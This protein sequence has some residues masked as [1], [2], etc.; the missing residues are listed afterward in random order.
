M[1][2]EI[3]NKA[4]DMRTASLDDAADLLRKVAGPRQADESLKSVFRRVGRRLS[5]WSQNRVRDVWRRDRRVRIRAEEVA[6]LRAIVDR[7]AAQ[8]T[9]NDE[10]AELRA[11]VA[12][13]ARYEAM[14]ERIDAEFFSPEISAARDQAWQARGVLGTNGLRLRS[15]N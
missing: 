5:G 15:R 9:A 7:D 1:K 3:F 6:Q 8:G 4:S 11:T 13:L 12:R 14:L 2:A 10:L